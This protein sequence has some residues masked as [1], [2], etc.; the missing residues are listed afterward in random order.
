VQLKKWA[1]LE[2]AGKMIG[3]YDIIV[4]ADGFGARQRCSFLQQTAFHSDKWA[5]HHRAEMS[6]FAVF[7]LSQ[8]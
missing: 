4:A 6:W 1:E 7:Y 2:S 5:E 8:R 3:F